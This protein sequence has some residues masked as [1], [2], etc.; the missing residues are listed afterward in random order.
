MNVYIVIKE[1][2]DHFCGQEFYKKVIQEVYLNRADA[3]KYVDYCNKV[4][5]ERIRCKDIYHI[6]PFYLQD[7]YDDKE[8]SPTG[9]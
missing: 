9:D 5:Q 1:Y 2:F 8:Q 3:E 7:H 6:E 4:Q